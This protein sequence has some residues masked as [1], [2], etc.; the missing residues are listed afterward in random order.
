LGGTTEYSIITDTL[1]HDATADPRI[2]GSPSSAPAGQTVASDGP[3]AVTPTLGVVPSAFSEEFVTLVQLELDGLASPPDVALLEANDRAWLDTLGDLLDEVDDTLE[4]VRVERNDER[5]LVVADFEAE[6]GVIRDRLRTVRRRVIGDDRTNGDEGSDDELVTSGLQLS[7]IEEHVVAWIG[8]PRTHSGNHEEIRALLGETGAPASGW[9]E[10]EP[11]PLPG[12]GKADALIAN[13]RDVLGW[14][15]AIGGK[16]E[17]E[18]EAITASLGWIGRVAVLAVDLTARGAVVPQLAQ[19]TT[20]K[21]Q[22]SANK[23]TYAVRWVPGLADP[24]ELERLATA[25][26]GAATAYD[27]QAD[28]RDVAQGALADLVDAICN[29]AALQVTVPAPPPVVNNVNDVAESVL[30][31]L[32]G[33]TFEAPPRAG[34]EI[35]RRLE[36]WGRPVTTPTKSTLVVALAEP[37]ESNA[38]L[39]SVFAPSSDGE[40]EP[41]E[42]ARVTAS[43]TRR[44]EVRDN[45]KRLEEL[46]PV[47]LRPGSQRRGEVLLSQEEA[48]EVM[49]VTGQTLQSAGFDVRVPDLSRRKATASLRLSSDD[50][51]S[52]V[53]AQQ[54]A[55]VRWSAVF[56]DVE[57]TADDIRNLAAQ[58]KPLVQSRGRWVELDHADLAEAA[59]ALAD[60]A[61]TTR[62]T[63]AEMLRHALGLE[64]SPLGGGISLDGNGWAANLLASAA[65][66]PEQLPTKPEGFRGELRSYQA[67]A[68]AWLGFLDQAGL[69]GCLALDMGLGKTPTMLAMLRQTKGDEPALAVLPPAVLGNW[70]GEAKKFTPGLKVL[71]HHG[72][73]RAQGKA[74]AKAA[75]KV[76]VVLTTYGTAVRDVEELSSITWR[77][78]VLDE[79]QVIKNPASETAQQ[80]RRIEAKMRVALTGTPIENGLGDLWAIMDFV[81]PGLVGPRAPFVAAL[82]VSG[83]AKAGAESALKALNGILVFRRTKA[84]PAIAAELPDR[85]DELDHCSM[86]PEQIG[87]YQAVLDEIVVNNAADDANK[88]KGQILAAITALKQI[89]NHPVN[90]RDDDKPLEGRSGKLIRLN[91]IIDQVFASDEKVLV[92]THFAS[93]GE[94]LAVYLSDRFDKKIDCYHGGLSRGA[95]DDMVDR[96]QSSEEAGAMV[97][98]LKAGGTGLNL[99]AASHVVLYDRWWNP[100]VE[101]QARDRVWRIGQTK[102]VIAHRL[103][104]PGTVDERVEEVVAG[105]RRIAD[106][107]LPKSSSIT[108]LDDDQLRAALGLDIDAVLID[109]DVLNGAG[110]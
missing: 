105:K 102:T 77:Q 91:E 18:A 88:K 61:D 72:P 15:V 35:A 87:L 42:V 62:L 98:S 47:L 30:A 85:I 16:A 8:G 19:V 103:V 10:Y 81:N 27:R 80:L 99:T 63:G 106:M 20:P 26:P 64:G 29:A 71:V 75:A 23:A 92:F 12:G 104:C 1:E 53:G 40:L 2:G 54:L 50:A 59:A 110:S 76:D 49:T 48:W 43:N 83:D 66:M 3:D 84:E 5:P 86:T 32:D 90:Y 69:G 60:R 36:Q 28:R 57:L 101:D 96:F 79:A 9:I 95:R 41:V 21:S 33:S 7:W 89:C 11:V 56:D 52:V 51:E 109:D 46:L 67:E 74:I 25:L 4:R 13:I 73:N 14:L 100:A 70:A 34:G 108:D 39:L 17:A 37:D 78:L 58:A 44:K 6:R 107:V 97:L 65:D 55:N 82:S 31:R 38:W 45:L 22:G 94:K 93:W 24:R 68:L